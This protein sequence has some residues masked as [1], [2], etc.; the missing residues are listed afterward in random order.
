M[1]YFDLI[2]NVTFDDGTV[3]KNLNYKFKLQSL[4]DD[5]VTTYRI[6]DGECLESICKD[7]YDDASLWWVLSTINDIRDVIFD[8]PITEETI[9]RFTK[10]M[11]TENNFL[12]MT[13][14]AENYDMLVAENDEKRTIKVIKPNLMQQIVKQIIRQVS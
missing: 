14:F 8:L 12:N 11:S 4:S 1:K 9:Q 6:K 5:Y 13:A 3:A 2:P 7:L 10:D